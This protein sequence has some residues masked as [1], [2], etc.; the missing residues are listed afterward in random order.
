MIYFDQSNGKSTRAEGDWE[1]QS[2]TNLQFKIG[3]VFP[4]D[5]VAKN[6]LCNA[7]HTGSI[8]GQEDSTLHGATK[9]VCHN[10]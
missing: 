7:E 1:C 10:C 2:R 5:L 9:L 8:P 4:D 6:Q 3:W